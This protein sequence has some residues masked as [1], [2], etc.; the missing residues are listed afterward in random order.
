M[1]TKTR[2][3]REWWLLFGRRGEVL[4]SAH[5][6]ETLPDPCD[7]EEVVHVREVLEVTDGK[8]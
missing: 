5:N 8:G 3:P 2:E 4:R 1:A 6:W 7:E